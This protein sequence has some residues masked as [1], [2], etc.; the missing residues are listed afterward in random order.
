MNCSDYGITSPTQNDELIYLD[1]TKNKQ[2]QSF[3]QSGSTSKL[4]N[5]AHDGKKWDDIRR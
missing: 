4:N 1:E 5:Y 2:N 3:N